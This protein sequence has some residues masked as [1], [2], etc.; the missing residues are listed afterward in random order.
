MDKLTIGQRLIQLRGDKSRNE[1]C[2]ATHIGLSALSNYENGYRIPRDE[3]KLVLA[4][5]YGKS[6]EELF[7]CPQTHET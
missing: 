2:N 4:R 5:Y 1:V 3:V 6:V 7:Y